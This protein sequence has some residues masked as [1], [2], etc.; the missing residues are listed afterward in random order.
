MRLA[1]ASS[2]LVLT[3]W[4]SSH[5]FGQDAKSN[6]PEPPPTP[7]TEPVA[8]QV[9]AR[10]SIKE[11]VSDGVGFLVASQNKDG[12]W[13]TGTETRGTEV[14]SMVPGSHDAFRVATT[15]LCVMALRE[16]A[17]ID[18][19]RRTPTTAGSST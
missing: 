16:A 4:T 12:S 10:A 15:A 7:P 9:R 2:L 8:E 18:A 14:Y 19:R 1:I 11:S 17:G 6:A 3:A 13:G 5:A